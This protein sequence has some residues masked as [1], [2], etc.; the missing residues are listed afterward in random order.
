[1][2]TYPAEM[3]ASICRLLGEYGWRPSMVRDLIVRMY[4]FEITSQDVERIFAKCVQE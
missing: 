1:M 3:I 2:E 4:G